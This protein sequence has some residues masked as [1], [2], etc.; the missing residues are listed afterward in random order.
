[1]LTRLKEAFARERLRL[2]AE[3]LARRLSRDA[4]LSVPVSV[5]F[6]PPHEVGGDAVVIRGRRDPYESVS[7]ILSTYISGLGSMAI[8]TQ[9]VR[10]ISQ[11]DLVREPFHKLDTSEIGV[12]PGAAE[13]RPQIHELISDFEEVIIEKSRSRWILSD[14]IYSRILNQLPPDTKVQR[15]FEFIYQY[16]GLYLS[17]LG[18]MMTIGLESSY[19]TPYLAQAVNALESRGLVVTYGGIVP[20]K[21]RFTFPNLEM[22]DDKSGFDGSPTCLVGETHGD[23]SAEVLDMELHDYLPRRT[24]LQPI[25]AEL[26]TEGGEEVLLVSR[27]T[28]PFGAR[29]KACGKYAFRALKKELNLLGFE[30]INRE[31]QT[32]ISLFGLQRQANGA[33]ADL[34]FDLPALTQ[35]TSTYLR[36]VLETRAT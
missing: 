26:G 28:V 33:W 3:F 10:I 14:R 9:D 6:T 17:E 4:R 16:P 21:K 31:D 36:R 24:M 18:R 25:V 2:F 19:Q 15:V 35:T 23:V 13:I 29:I 30:A 7:D 32:A 5:S 12:S 22:L 20:G 11:K 27:Q 8:G 1:M 34:F